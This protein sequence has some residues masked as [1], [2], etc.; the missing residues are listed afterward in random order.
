MRKEFPE[1]LKTVAI[2]KLVTMVEDCINPRDRQET[3]LAITKELRRR[4][5]QANFDGLNGEKY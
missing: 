4:I 2:M 1:E 5:T 3:V